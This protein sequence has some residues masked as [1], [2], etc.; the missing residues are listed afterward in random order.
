MILCFCFDIM[1]HLGCLRAKENRQ[2]SSAVSVAE[3]SSAREVT[4]KSLCFAFFRYF[5]C[6]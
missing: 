1:K 2:P 4:I 5:G 3:V 6:K